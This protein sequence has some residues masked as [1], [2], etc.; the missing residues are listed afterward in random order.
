MLVHTYTHSHLPLSSS[1]NIFLLTVHEEAMCG[2]LLVWPWSGDN[3]FAEGWA[4]N[5]HCHPH[6]LLSA[7]SQRWA[8]TRG[9]HLLACGHQSPNLNLLLLSVIK[10]NLQVTWDP[11][12]SEKWAW[13]QGAKPDV[14]GSR[15][16]IQG[17][18][19]L[20]KDSPPGDSH[21]SYKSS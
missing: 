17:V 18:W 5:G 7:S 19:T 12:C 4:P 10:C 6:A 8:H 21:S 16:P 20:N 13:E 11:C 9:P 15:P 3:L 2:N 1:T 14:W